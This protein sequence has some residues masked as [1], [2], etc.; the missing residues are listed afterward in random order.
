M[1]NS[2]VF[3]NDCHIEGLLSPCHP[4]VVCEQKGLV[5]PIAAFL[6]YRR[7]LGASA[8]TLRR[9]SYWL[10]EY[11]DFLKSKGYSIANVTERTVLEFIENGAKR[12][13]NVTFLRKSDASVSYL[14]T[15]NTKRDLI[16][17]FLYVL[18]HKLQ[19][20]EGVVSLSGSQRRGTLSMKDR[21]RVSIGIAGDRQGDEIRTALRAAKERSRRPRPTPSA[22]QA[23][24]IIAAA[25]K[26][27]GEHSPATYYLFASLQNKAGAR[28]GGVCDLTVTSLTTCLLEEI[29][30]QIITPIPHLAKLSGNSP[31]RNAVRQAVIDSLKA[32]RAKGRKFVFA[33]VIEK[34]KPARGLPIPIELCVEL[35]EYIWN[36]RADF[37]D[38]RATAGHPPS[39]DYV[40]LS[41]TTGNQYRRSSVG[42]VLKEL[43]DATGVRGSGH[44][45]RAAFCEDIVRELYLRE[46]AKNGSHYDADTI[47]LLAAEYLGH[48]DPSTLRPYLNNVLKQ[49]TSLEGQPVI[50]SD[51]DA[52]KMEM[53]ARALA[54]PGLAADKLRQILWKVAA[55]LSATSM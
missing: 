10:A 18:E 45:L 34:G 49:E 6:A 32:L 53:I 11:W 26:W 41:Q 51:D 17:S 44:R 13:S 29:Q 37:L 38:K 23:N 28:A 30:N 16:Y 39:P 33:S 50:F 5:L 36:E 15:L 4:S 43:F 14:E 9:D 42:R 8:E 55:G 24:E 19:L 21:V 31:E 52:P 22:S 2:R 27:R 3:R 7:K 20:I 46:K 47:L 12:S 35:I 1:E 54:E 48:R 25:L 40:F